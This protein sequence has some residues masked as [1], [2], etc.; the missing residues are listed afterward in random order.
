MQGGKKT[1]ILTFKKENKE[2]TPPFHLL[3]FR[4]GAACCRIVPFYLVIETK[5]SVFIKE[6]NV[7]SFTANHSIINAEDLTSC[8]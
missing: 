2:K 1:F 8:K 7:Y 6:E 4:I 3:W 5:S